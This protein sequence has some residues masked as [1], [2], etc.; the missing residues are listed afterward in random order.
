LRTLHSFPTRRSS[1]LPTARLSGLF[2]STAGQISRSVGRQFDGLEQRLYLCPGGTLKDL[3]DPLASQVR[4]E[5][6]DEIVHE[7][8]QKGPLRSEEHTSELQSRENL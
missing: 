3:F 4:C 2:L 8:T 6:L 1:D 5:G 7:A